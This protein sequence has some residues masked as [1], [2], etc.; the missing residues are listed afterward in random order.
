MQFV[1]YTPFF[2]TCFL[3]V[4]CQLGI[5]NNR[6]SDINTISDAESKLN[7]LINDKSCNATFQC[8]VIAYGERACG[9]PSKFD[10][11]SI[12]NTKQEEVEFI[13]NEITQFEKAYNKSSQHLSTCE[14]NTSPQ[15]LCIN[16]VCELVERAH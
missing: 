14:H 5:S 12:K 11:Y 3:L 1:K 4:G 7:L 6:A 13:A 2:V 8:R 16:K 15:T 10:I 9:G